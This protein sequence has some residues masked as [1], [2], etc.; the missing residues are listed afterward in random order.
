[1][2]IKKTIYRYK[3]EKNQTV[4]TA[5]KPDDSIEYT[6]KYRLYTSAPDIYALT[7]GRLFVDVIDVRPDE[8]EIW[9]EVLLSD[10]KVEVYT[11]SELKGDI[12][13]IKTEQDMQSS[14]LLDTMDALASSYE[15]SMT[16]KVDLDSNSENVLVSMGAIADLYELVLHVQLRLDELEGGAQ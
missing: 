5:I 11:L 4:I 16:M 10:I 12:E 2:I 1:M 6:I 14:L 9:S 15:D 13:N 7:D 3:N 8:E